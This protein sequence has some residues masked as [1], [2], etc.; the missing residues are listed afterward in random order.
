M[1]Q[2]IDERRDERLRILDM[3][4]KLRLDVLRK[5]AAAERAQILSQFFQT[6]RASREQALEDLGRQWYDIQHERR[7][8]VNTIPEYGLQYRPTAVQNIREAIAYNKEVSILSGIAKHRGF[9]AAPD[10]KGTNGNEMEEDLEAIAVSAPVPMNLAGHGP[11]EKMADRFNSSSARTPDIPTG[12]LR[13]ATLAA[14]LRRYGRRSCSGSCRRAVSGADALG[15]SQPSV[16]PRPKET[17]T[18]VRRNARKSTSSERLATCCTGE[19]HV[20]CRS[21]SE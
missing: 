16:T 14:G 12:S 17:L 6:I 21:L 20:Q 3:E 11:G 4:Y 15:K 13:I 7:R 1:M 18:T 10:I 19:Q 9:P 8:H 2:C 5:R